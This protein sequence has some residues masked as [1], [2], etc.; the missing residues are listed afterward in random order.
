M[1]LTIEDLA[2]YPRTAALRVCL[3]HGGLYENRPDPETGYQQ[4]CHDRKDQEKWDGYDINEWIRLCDCC[5]AVPMRSGSKWSPF[6]CH[7]CRPEIVAA[8]RGIPIGRHSIMN[9]VAL[10]NFISMFG[11][12][13][14]LSDWK[15]QR[16]RHLTEAE[17][18]PSLTE[19][20]Q[21]NTNPNRAVRDL[22]A[23]WDAPN[24]ADP[25]ADDE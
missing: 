19:F 15:S 17:Q 3:E 18:D 4:R 6:I 14:R 11:A 24:P 22:L 10:S 16:V 1:D 13:D 25:D 2:E 9:R 12:I 23:W 5:L 21:T 8:E 20:L 7:N